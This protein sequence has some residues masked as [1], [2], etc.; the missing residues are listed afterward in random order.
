MSNCVFLC[1]SLIWKHQGGKDSFWGERKLRENLQIWND[2]HCTLCTMCKVFC[3]QMT[4]QI[5]VLGLFDELWGSLGGKP[6]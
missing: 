2:V 3:M 1:F 5:L 4:T 6:I